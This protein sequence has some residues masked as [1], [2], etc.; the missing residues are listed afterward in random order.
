MSL[1]F[2]LALPTRSGIGVGAPT[3]GAGE[4]T[5]GV[6]T[7]NIFFLDTKIKLTVS[8]KTNTRLA[9]R[10][11]MARRVLVRITIQKAIR[12]MIFIKTTQGPQVIARRS[13]G[14]HAARRGWFL[15]PE[16]EF[17]D[18][19]YVSYRYEISRF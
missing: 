10:L 16:R 4:V 13:A 5:D 11:R 7:V 3:V 8:H 1:H 12:L 6:V 15:F 14:V 9:R 2:S 17:R 19:F 18:I